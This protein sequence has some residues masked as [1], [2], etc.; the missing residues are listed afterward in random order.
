MDLNL[1][2][3]S[4][5]FIKTVF[6]ADIPVEETS[7]I[8]VPDDRPDILRVLTA[9]ANVFVRNKSADSGKVAVSGLVSGAVLY[10]PD[11]GGDVQKIE[12]GIPFS[13]FSTANDIDDETRIVANA[14]LVACDVK[15]LNPR[16]III[17][18][19]VTVSVSCYC[20]T[21]ASIPNLT[22]EDNDCVEILCEEKHLFTAAGVSEKTF[23]LNDEIQPQPGKPEI[24]EVLSS[25]TS[26]SADEAKS[27]GNKL[28]VKGT[29]YS[30]ILYRGEKTGE[31]SRI[32]H[33]SAFSQILE[34]DTKNEN[35][36]FDVSMLLESAYLTIEPIGAG[37]EWGIEQEL[38]VIIQCVTSAEMNIRYIS[39]AYCTKFET[40]S[41]FESIGFSHAEEPVTLA[42]TVRGT[43]E[44]GDTV[45]NIIFAS[46]YAG[47]VQSSEGENGTEAASAVLFTVMFEAENGNIDCVS[48]KVSAAVMF[49][50]GGGS[51]NISARIAGDVNV[52]VG[53][54]GFEVRASVEFSARKRIEEAINIVK[55]ISCDESACRNLSFRPSV[56]V[57]KVTEGE[58]MW[59]IAKKYDS[60]I[61]LIESANEIDPGQMP[62][63]SVYLI[64]PKKR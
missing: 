25:V 61:S 4:F 12:I 53:S 44:C 31:I 63:Q 58:T 24:G 8:I 46:A 20:R 11:G 32:Q 55:K 2:N 34:L 9:T 50:G 35:M 21:T 13:A 48:K 5:D 23:V 3:D 52:V 60:S 57:H 14:K 62:D 59:G 27:V 1:K 49:D 56:S 64:I 45:K 36:I 19:E 7:E 17:K 40:V 28:I 29:A 41:E 33:T 39:D 38:H 18:A 15:I 43:I 22:E 30:D 42:E 37:G 16:K 6:E 47:S 51:L 54:G 26:V 10:L